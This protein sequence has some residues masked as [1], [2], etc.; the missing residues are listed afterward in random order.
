MRKVKNLISSA[1]QTAT[2]LLNIRTVRAWGWGAE[3]E[4]ERERIR[5]RERQSKRKKASILRAAN[6]HILS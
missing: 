4:R 3:R 6:I 1:L 2:S 5:E